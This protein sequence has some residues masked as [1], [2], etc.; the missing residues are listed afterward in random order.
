VAASLTLRVGVVAGT[1]AGSVGL[2]PIKRQVGLVRLRGNGRVRMPVPRL[3]ELKV[4]ISFARG[5]WPDE[6]AIRVGHR[7][8]GEVVEVV[9]S[10]SHLDPSDR[11]S[12]AINNPP[13]EWFARRQAELEGLGAWGTRLPRRS[14][15]GGLDIYGP[16]S[17]RR[18]FV[19]M[20][21]DEPPHRVR[22]GFK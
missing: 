6:Y 14:E 2:V 12:L 17:K 11:Q 3:M 7:A 1:S 8:P 13:V 15:P 18:L 4:N 10:G 16:A 9:A 21:K 20:G 5:L 22:P 19:H